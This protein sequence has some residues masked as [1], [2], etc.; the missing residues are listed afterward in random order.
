METRQSIDLIQVANGVNIE[1]TCSMCS[2]SLVYKYNS[3]RSNNLVL[4]RFSILIV[5]GSVST[6]CCRLNNFGDLDLAVRNVRILN[7]SAKRQFVSRSKLGRQ[8]G[9][10]IQSR[11]LMDYKLPSTIA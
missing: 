7:Q 11:I 2:S 9:S 4:K 10:A 6:K 1:V 5:Y 3:L 8:L